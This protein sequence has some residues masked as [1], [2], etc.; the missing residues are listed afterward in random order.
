MFQDFAQSN[1]TESQLTVYR[2]EQL[3]YY[4]YMRRLQEK[5]NN[6]LG[7]CAVFNGVY[8]REPQKLFALFDRAFD[9]T[10]MKGELLKFEKGKCIYTIEKFAEKSFEIER[11]K[12]FFKNCLESNFTRDFIALPTSF[13]VGNGKNPNPVSVKESTNEIIAAIAEYDIVHIANNE[14]SLSELERTHKMLSELYAEKQN[15]DTKYS[16]LV[17]QKKQYKVVLLLCLVVIGCAI[18]L[19]TFNSNLKNRDSQI[20]DLK[21]QVQNQET[22]IENLNANIADLQIK[23]NTLTNEKSKLTNEKSKLTN[24]LQ[25]MKSERDNLY[26]EVS[27][28]ESRNRR[29]QSDVDEYKKY[30]PTIY[31]ATTTAW[32]YYTTN[33]KSPSSENCQETRCYTN[34]GYTVNVYKIVNGYGLTEYGWAKMSDWTKY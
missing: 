7:F 9:E 13:K 21:N 15:L 14:K 34:I 5:T 10:L 3:I 11:I 32:Y 17:S 25:T 20:K 24:D 6:F 16:K 23:N 26:S 19:F 33:C 28:L 1:N 27:R 30:K 8:C 22:D 18:G 29:L 2:K 12:T 4:T 31:K